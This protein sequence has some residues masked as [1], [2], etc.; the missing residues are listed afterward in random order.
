MQNV[1]KWTRGDSYEHF[2]GRWS[3][4]AA[5]EFIDWLDAPKG[6]TWL[7]VGCGTGALTRTLLAL[8]EPSGVVG[9][10]P[11]EAF[12]DFAKKNNLDPRASFEIGSAMDLPV[13]PASYDRVVSGL[14]LNFV[15]D[16]GKALAE[17]KL[18]LR[19]GGQVAAYVWDY[20]D[21]M[22]MLRVFWD[23]AS[24]VDP[25]NVDLDEQFRFPLNNP[26]ALT[27]LFQDGQLTNVETGAIEFR[28]EFKDFD[29]Y[30][31]PFLGGA[32]PAPT[33]V[34]GLTDKHKKALEQE[35]R[36]RLT[37]K[38]DGSIELLARAWAVKGQCSD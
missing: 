23:A 17:M 3:P 2:M 6:L 15:P 37:K 16:A 26:G 34:A 24:E 12:I 13:E 21:G 29:D 33:Y 11:S 22:Q 28:M 38:P 18:A 5:A 8:A 30:W 1:D 10:D 32:G 31:Q 35:L 14:V 7:D 9:I 36:R 19:A 20:A 25:Q 4:K 27:K